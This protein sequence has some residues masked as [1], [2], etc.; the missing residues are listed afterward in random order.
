[1][2][3]DPVP[4]LLLAA[5]AAKGNV[6]PK[7]D[8]DY[9]WNITQWQAG[10]SHGNPAEPT[11]SWYSFTVSG[12]V[13]GSLASGSYIPAFGA[14]CNGF[15]A[16][17]PLSSNYSECAI[18]SEVSETGAFV[19]ARIVPGVDNVQAHIAISYVFS[20]TDHERNYTAVAVTDWARE[21]PPYNFT[22]TPSEVV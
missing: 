9:V 7:D 19:S 8:G 13:Y 2:R 21:R 16:G 6:V 22:L 15:G 10:L 17:F 12:S 3:F 1:M 5:S 4:L 18:N 20:N 11:T 14:T